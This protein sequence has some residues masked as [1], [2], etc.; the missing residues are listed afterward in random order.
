[1]AA[2][3][4]FG[5]ASSLDSDLPEEFELKAGATKRTRGGRSTRRVSQ[6]EAINSNESVFAEIAYDPQFESFTLGI[7][8]VNAL[9]L[10]VDVQYNHSS[11]KDPETGKMPLE[12]FSVVLENCFCAFF[13]FEVTVRFLA[14]KRKINCLFDG[15]FVFDF[16][17]VMLMLIETWFLQIAAAVFATGSS[18]DVLANFSALRLLRLLRL[19]RMARLMRAL[20]ELLTLVKGMIKAAKAVVW[21]FVLLFALLYMFGIMFTSTYMAAPKTR[22]DGYIEA[23]SAATVNHLSPQLQPLSALVQTPAPDPFACEE[24]GDDSGGDLFATLG[25]SMMNLLT[26]G[27]LGD[28]LQE[29]CDAIKA[30]SDIMQAVFFVFFGLTFALLLNMLIG[31]L[32]EVVSASAKDEEE[33]MNVNYLKATIKDAFRDL[34]VNKDGVVCIEE[35]NAIKNKPKVRSSMVEIGMEEDRLDVQ[36]QQMQDIVFEAVKSEAQPQLDDPRGIRCSQAADG[37]LG[38]T[39][40]QLM[41]QLIEVRPGQEASALDFEILKLTFQKNVKSFKSTLERIEQ[42]V[43]TAVGPDPDPDDDEDESPRTPDHRPLSRASIESVREDE[44]EDASSYIVRSRGSHPGLRQQPAR[45]L[46]LKALPTEVLFRELQRRTAPQPG[47]VLGPGCRT[48]YR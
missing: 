19:A 34:D 14:F 48:A 38:V 45:S 46:D 2:V 6:H 16:V 44:S 47:V 28:N 7:I 5:E 23:L 24:E 22:P 15:F 36:L 20:P 30:E 41:E 37:R 18:S 31:V 12:P 9:W 27:V 11:M 43:R 21:I 35:W 39:V 29:T 10:F 42:H 8:V 4:E 25:D 3:K 26:R 40:D 33:V 17:L 1:M 13:T 32:C